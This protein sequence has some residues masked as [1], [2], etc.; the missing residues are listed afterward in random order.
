MS[1]TGATVSRKAAPA[2]P[3]GKRP[4]P[5]DMVAYAIGMLLGADDFEAEQLYHRGRLARALRYLHGAGT[6]AGLRVEW[7][8]PL[9]EGADADFPRGREEEVRVQPGVAVD[10]LGRLIEVPATAC[11]RLQRWYDAQEPD[12]LTAAL[13]PK[14]AGDPLAGIVVDLFIRHH[15]CERGK[16]PAFA[17]GPF[18]ALDAVRP[19]RLR[20][21]YKL[22]LILRDESPPPLPLNPWTN[23]SGIADP[24]QRWRTLQEDIFKAWQEGSESTSGGWGTDGPAPLREHVVGQDTTSLF[25]A[26]LTL[27]AVA[28][29]TNDTR[30]ARQQ[31]ET[32]KVDNHSRPFVYTTGA[33]ARW[34]G[35]TM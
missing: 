6:V 9:A 5:P 15:L 13:H 10:R 32:V 25:L 14:E 3:L 27:P 2:D 12:R 7:V 21:F 35:L 18:D 16:T 23:L 17:D 29:E 33:L 26:R 24:A 20:E 1:T 11:I 31:G 22:E 30:P 28:A 19:A 34:L 4:E 8:A